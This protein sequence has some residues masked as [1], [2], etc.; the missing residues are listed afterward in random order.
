MHSHGLADVMPTTMQGL[1]V[2]WELLFQLPQGLQIGCL[3]ASGI[4]F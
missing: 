3:S 1:S 4:E 2:T